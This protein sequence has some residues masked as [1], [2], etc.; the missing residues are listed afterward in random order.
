MKCTSSVHFCPFLENPKAQ[1]VCFYLWVM[2][3]SAVRHWLRIHFRK[4]FISLLWEIKKAIKT[5]IAF[6]SFSIK[7]FFN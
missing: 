6:F 1:K 4:V 7:T 5:L 3:T 2:L